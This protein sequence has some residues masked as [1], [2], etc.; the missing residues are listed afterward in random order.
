MQAHDVQAPN[1][2]NDIHVLIAFAGNSQ[3]RSKPSAALAETG[4]RKRRGHDVALPPSTIHHPPGPAPPYAYDEDDES[5]HHR[6]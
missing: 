4:E 5:F 1:D 6:N 3:T 2:P